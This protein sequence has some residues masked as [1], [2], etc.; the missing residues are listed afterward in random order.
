[1][2]CPNT[3]TLRCQDSQQR[4]RVQINVNDHLILDNPKGDWETERGR[5]DYGALIFHECV[6]LLIFH[7]CVVPLGQALKL[8]QYQAT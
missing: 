3:V 2:L 5:N 8:E 1:M 4:A 6:V 7:E